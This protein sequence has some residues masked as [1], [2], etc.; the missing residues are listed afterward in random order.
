MHKF[1]K[2]GRIVNFPR[3]TFDWKSMRNT[4]VNKTAGIAI[5]SSGVV[6][7]IVENRIAAI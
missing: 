6:C 7:L 2:K 3:G 5:S 1:N 4:A